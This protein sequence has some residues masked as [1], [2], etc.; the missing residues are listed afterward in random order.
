MPA[1]FNPVDTAGL[2]SALQ[3]ASVGPPTDTTIINLQAG[4]TY[5]LT[6]VNNYW[7]G[8]DG[9]PPID[10]FVFIHGNGATI[11]RDPSA[12]DFRLF[13]VSG[14]MELTRGALTMDNVTLQG[15]M[16]KGGASD[17][18]GGG[19]GAGGAIFN[20]G[21]L[22]LTGVTLYNNEALGGASGVTSANSYAGGG[23]GGDASGPTAGGFGGSLGGTFGGAGGNGGTS[24]GGGGGGFL[25]GANGADGST[26]GAGGGNGGFGSGGHDGGYGGGSFASNG[27]GGTGG[28]FGLG[29]GG[30]DGGGG[31]GVGGGGG[32]INDRTKDNVGPGGGF[33]GGGGVGFGDGPNG[34]IGPGG[35]GGIGGAGGFGGGGG[36]AETQ[37]GMGGTG[38]F[39]GGN[40]GTGG[41]GAALGGAGGGGAGLGGA[42]FNMGAD[43]AHPS[44]AATLINC[45][46]A[47]NFAVGG[48]VTPLS[49]SSGSGFGGALFNLDG[50]VELD[51]DTIVGNHTDA[52]GGTQTGFASAGKADGDAVYNLAFGN[53][54]D[55]GSPVAATLVLNNSILAST[56]SVH[57]L[58]SQAINGNGTNTATVSGS[59]NLVLSS[60]GTVAPGVITLTTNP[61]L[62]PMQNNG[63]PTPTLLP[64]VGSPVLGAGDPSQAPSF[65]QRGQ[66]RP[67]GGPI[68]LGSVQV[69]VGSNTGGGGGGGSSSSPHTPTGQLLPFALGIVNNQLD[70]FFL[71]QK[72]AVFAEAF[73][74]NNFF[75]PNPADAQF[76]GGLIPDFPTSSDALGYPAIQAD[77]VS[78]GSFLLPM[79]T[80]PLNFMSPVVLND[81]IAALQTAITIQR[82]EMV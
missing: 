61:N 12:P 57:N 73:T 82:I 21:A 78:S 6:A 36:T 14:G 11:Q 53:D 23:M 34:G 51:S 81:L 75:N 56:P 76:I 15:G 59:H 30:G 8:P 49:G 3:S 48:D 67:S 80:I 1:T 70:I 46:L 72:E 77:L 7:Y 31:G 25:T 55:S 74:F 60:S 62:G 32:G 22:N 38:G 4:T 24:L 54:I 35:F 58:V 39:G 63:G 65:D 19:L 13:Y 28:A 18:G 27:I 44:G 26:N 9:L 50:Q 29:G 5:T 45:T 68:D 41:V 64:S 42:I 40:G 33:G 20:Q 16:A 43:S 2:I 66:P 79:I 47:G 10:S 17:Q 52:G 71:D 37:P 69:S